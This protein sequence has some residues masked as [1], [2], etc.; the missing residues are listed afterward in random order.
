L[1]YEVAIHEVVLR[2]ETPE[3]SEKSSGL[4]QACDPR[5]D[6]DFLVFPK[7][8]TAA[9]GTEKVKNGKIRNNFVFSRFSLRLKR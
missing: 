9:Q 7:L 5:N 2:P 6:D 1:Q 4:P 8:P 3:P